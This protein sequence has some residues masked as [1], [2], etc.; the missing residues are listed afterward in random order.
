MAKHGKV[1]GVVSSYY[2]VRYHQSV[3][4]LLLLVYGRGF[5][6]TVGWLIIGSDSHLIRILPF[7]SVEIRF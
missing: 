6:R 5:S 1:L 3:T 4:L 7:H 2:C